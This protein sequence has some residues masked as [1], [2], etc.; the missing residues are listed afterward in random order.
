M[1][2]LTKIEWDEL[3]RESDESRQMVGTEK[4]TIENKLKG[5]WADEMREF[6]GDV[7]F[8]GNVENDV[9]LKLEPKRNF[10]QRLK[11]LFTGK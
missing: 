2:F 1:D 5:S 6:F 11:Y 8:S 4:I 7:E 3:T 9:E 10:W